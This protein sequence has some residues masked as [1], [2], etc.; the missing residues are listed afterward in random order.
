LLLLLLYD[1]WNIRH[2]R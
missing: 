1:L 2:Q